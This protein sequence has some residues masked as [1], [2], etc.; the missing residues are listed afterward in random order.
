[1]NHRVRPRPP[2][3]RRTAVA[4]ALLCLATAGCGGSADPAEDPAP[5]VVTDT[6]QTLPSQPGDTGPTSASPAAQPP[7][8]LTATMADFSIDLGAGSVPAGSYTVEVVNEGGSSHD[9]VVERDGER[10]A[11]ADAVDPGRTG[12]LTVT[13]EPGEYVLYCSIADHRA[14]GMET[15]IEV[16]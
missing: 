15:T 6:A 3:A 7:A 5:T 16:T 11:A 14:M 8:A 9:L 12:T 13:L 10:V 2:A 1:M 4:A